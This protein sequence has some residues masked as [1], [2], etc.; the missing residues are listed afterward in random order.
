M[1]PASDT[2]H[3]RRNTIAWVA[4]N[5]V[6]VAFFLAMAAF[7]WIEPE[8]AE[9][10]G[11]SGGAALVWFTTAVPIALAALILNLG[12]LAWVLVRRSRQGRWPVSRVAWLSVLLWVCAL[13]VD[14][15]RHGA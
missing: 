13:A 2:L 11:A 5:V 7:S 14:N 15:L 6:A 8:L 10:P 12:V 3:Q 1:N 9:V 4:A